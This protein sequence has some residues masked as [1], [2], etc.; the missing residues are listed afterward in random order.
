LAGNI[1]DRVLRGRA[2][3]IGGKAQIAQGTEL[4]GKTQASM[5]LPLVV[6]KLLIGVR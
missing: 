5:G 3:V 1:E 6:D 4:Q 2:E